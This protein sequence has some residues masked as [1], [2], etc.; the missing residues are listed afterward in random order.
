LSEASGWKYFPLSKG[1]FGYDNIAVSL[2]FVDCKVPLT[3][4]LIAEMVHNGWVCNYTF[5]RDNKPFEDPSGNYKK[6]YT[7]LGD[8]R[9][10]ACASTPFAQLPQ[11]EKDKDLIIA[12]FVLKCL[13][14][15]CYQQK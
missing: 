10:N 6:P 5:W 13:R 15:S 12:D 2:G 11:D 3:R 8:E 14:E 9:R 7:P 1:S 4:E